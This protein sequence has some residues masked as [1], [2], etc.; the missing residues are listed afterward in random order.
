MIPSQERHTRVA[1]VGIGFG[2]AFC[3]LEVALVGHLV[4]S[5]FGAGEELAGVTMAEEVCVSFS[6]HLISSYADFLRAE[7]SLG[8]TRECEPRHPIW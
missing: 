3:D 5:G 6:S 4:E 1:V 2:G 7:N 8:H